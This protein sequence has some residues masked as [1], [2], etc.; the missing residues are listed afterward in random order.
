MRYNSFGTEYVKKIKKF[1]RSGVL[2]KL[3]KPRLDNVLNFSIPEKFFFLF[4]LAVLLLA[5]F[6][7]YENHWK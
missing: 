3:I 2:Q 5:V 1:Q 4:C 7:V 6:S